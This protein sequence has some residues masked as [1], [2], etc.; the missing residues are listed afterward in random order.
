MERRYTC[1]NCAKECELIADDDVDAMRETLCSECRRQISL[2]ERTYQQS[3]LLILG[4]IG[5]M[6]LLLFLIR[7]RI[8]REITS[9]I[10]L[11]GTPFLLFF[12]MFRVHALLSKTHRNNW[13]SFAASIIVAFGLVVALLGAI[14]GFRIPSWFN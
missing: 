4:A 1:K 11:L 5:S 13:A 10:L 2:P 8:V 14:V 7:L 3:A 6:A 12:L 9:V